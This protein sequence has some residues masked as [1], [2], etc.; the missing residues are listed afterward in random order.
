[1]E[2][3]LRLQS[4]LTEVKAELEAAAKAARDQARAK[5]ALNTKKHED[6]PPKESVAESGKSAD[7]N[8]TL[9]A[10]EQR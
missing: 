4:T 3:N 2:E 7:E 6:A 9:F 10:G 8:M 5:S 1:V